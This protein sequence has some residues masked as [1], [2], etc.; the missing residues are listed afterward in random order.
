MGCVAVFTARESTV[1]AIIGPHHQERLDPCRFHAFVQGL[2]N[3]RVQ[4]IELSQRLL[5]HGVV[6]Q[7]F[8]VDVQFP[9]VFHE[10]GVRVKF[11][12]LSK[13]MC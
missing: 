2:P 1:D 5:D 6:C 4:Q 11:S 7:S 10:W 9:L 12:T 8:V 13:Y 3:R